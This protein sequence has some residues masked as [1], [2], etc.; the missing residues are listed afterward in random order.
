MQQD[1]SNILQENRFA[2]VSFLTI[3]TRR[4]K[5]AL[6]FADSGDSAKVFFHIFIQRFSFS[7]SSL[8]FF[9]FSFLLFCDVRV[10]EGAKRVSG[11][12]K[13]SKKFIFSTKKAPRWHF[14]CHQGAGGKTTITEIRVSELQANVTS[15]PKQQKI[16]SLST[17]NFF[18]YSLPLLLF[19]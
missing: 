17:Y 19:C 4:E 1:S 5:Y 9:F 3:S 7:I 12:G 18:L 2:F 6:F 8:D 13:M 11:P 16:L 10:E 14:E 15:P